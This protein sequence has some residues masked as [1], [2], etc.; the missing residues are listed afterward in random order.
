MNS[1]VLGERYEVQQQLGKKAGRRTLLARDLLTGELVVVKLLSF[2]SDFEWDDLKLF[3]REAETLKSLSHPAIPGYLDYFEVNSPPFKGFALVQTYIPAKTLEQYLKSGR[4]FTEAELKQLA[5]RLLEILVYLHGRQPPV[6]HRDIKPSNILLSNRSGN[7]IG[8]LYL[9]DFGSVQTAAVTEGGSMTVVGTYGYMPQE[10]FGGRTVPASDLYSAGATLIYLAC[11]IHP[12][13]LP[14]KDFQV[15]FEQVTNLSPAFTKWLKQMTQPNLERRFHSATEALKALEQPLTNNITSLVV[16]QPVGSKIKLTKDEHTLEILIPPSGYQPSMTFLVLFAIAWNSFIL[17]WTLNALAAPFPANIPFA[18]FSLPFW[19]AGVQMVSWVLSPLLKSIR[20]H[21]DH[22][23][24]AFTWELLGLKFN[25]VAP[26]AR[27][28]ITKLVYVKKT[29]T[30]DPDGNKV[31]VPSQLIIWAGV[32]KYQV[33]GLTY[34]EPELEWLA[35]ELS[36]WLGLPITR[37]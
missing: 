15:Q 31:E 35:H 11:G 32:Q 19:G 25:R 2:S 24:I 21:I 29:F 18:L 33:G 9:V 10:Q 12:A 16:G 7:S 28:D 36:D 8:Q 23:K 3:E 34:S 26:S 4:T 14:Q 17:F 22:Q 30:T 1:Q 27:Q 13:D 5:K 20:L 6:I 37:E